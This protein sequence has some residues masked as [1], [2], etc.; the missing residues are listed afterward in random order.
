M[1]RHPVFLSSPELILTMSRLEMG[2]VFSVVRE[3]NA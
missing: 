1:E 3:E 2:S